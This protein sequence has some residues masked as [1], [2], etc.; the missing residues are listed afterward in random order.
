MLDER[1]LRQIFLPPFQAAVDAGVM[2]AMEAYNEVGGEPMIGSSRYLKDMLRGD[3]GFEGVLLSDF[4]EVRN[5]YEFHWVAPGLLESVQLAMTATSLDMSMELPS[6]ALSSDFGDNLAQLVRTGAV[7]ER[8][9]DESVRRLLR[10]KATL[11]L[12]DEGG[13][14]LPEDDVL[15]PT[16]GSP[17][18]WNVSLAAAREALTLVKNVGNILPL[19]HDANLLVTGPLCNSVVAQAGGWTYHWQGAFD[20]H[21]FRTGVSIQRAFKELGI[22]HGGHVRALLSS[23]LVQHIACKQPLPALP[24]P[25]LLSSSLLPP[26]FLLLTPSSFFLLSPCAPS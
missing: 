13:I 8:R 22:F 25:L 16:V 5:L 11:G 19:P 21:E 14:P 3:L 23:L 17:A 10:M 4:G 6:P 20:E 7:P 24:S 2:S 18:D 9:L 1:S 15:L 26:L 12:L